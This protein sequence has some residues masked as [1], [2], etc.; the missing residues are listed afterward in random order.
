[1]KKTWVTAVVV[2][3]LALGLVFMGCEKK[4]E[5]QKAVNNAPEKI[6][7]SLTR[8]SKDVAAKAEIDVLRKAAMEMKDKIVAQQDQVKKLT[9]QMKA[10][11]EVQ[12]KT[13]QGQIDTVNKQIDPLK[14][15]LAEQVEKI[16]KAGGDTSDLKVP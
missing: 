2:S 11:A 10:A 6:G 15:Q 9:E 12:A 5:E 8:I 4:T 14:K 1:M 16:K 3:I 13:L 7:D